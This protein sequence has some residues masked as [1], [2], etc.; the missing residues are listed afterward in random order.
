M[1]KWITLVIAGAW[2]AASGLAAA[3]VVIKQRPLTWD[4]VKGQ[5]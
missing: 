3:E 1:K 4:D 5:I 2:L